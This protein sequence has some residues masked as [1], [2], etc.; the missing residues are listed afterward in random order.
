MRLG[1]SSGDEGGKEMRLDGLNKDQMERWP[2][3][4][5]HRERTV[6]VRKE[7]KQVLG[8]K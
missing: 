6:L 7:Q 3:L 4:G 8:C 5:G 1:Q 2:I